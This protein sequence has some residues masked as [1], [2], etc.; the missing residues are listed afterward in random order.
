MQTGEP[1]E[2]FYPPPCDGIIYEKSPH[3]WEV[4]ISGGITHLTASTAT[5][6]I[7]IRNA[8]TP[9]EMLEKLKETFTKMGWDQKLIYSDYVIC[10]RNLI[11]KANFESIYAA[12][13]VPKMQKLDD[14]WLAG[15]YKPDYWLPFAQSLMNFSV[16]D[17]SD[18]QIKIFMEL[19]KCIQYAFY[20][21]CIEQKLIEGS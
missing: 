11:T 15:Q 8:K 2:N 17:D 18:V 6:T 7:F 21:W 5:L 4:N 3:V 20:C 12:T 16:D 10:R 9:E 14:L 19:P 1:P 13:V